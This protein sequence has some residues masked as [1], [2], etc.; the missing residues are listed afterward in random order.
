MRKAGSQV[1]SIGWVPALRNKKAREAG[2]DVRALT[3]G[4]YF[5]EVM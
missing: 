2:T 3:G 1:S 4:N 5:F